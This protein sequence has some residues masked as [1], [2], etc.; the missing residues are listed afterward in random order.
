MKTEVTEKV[1]AQTVPSKV[2][3]GHI[4]SRNGFIIKV[5]V[6]YYRNV[7]ECFF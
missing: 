3:I 1:F 7:S 6:R 2:L 4:L 5:P